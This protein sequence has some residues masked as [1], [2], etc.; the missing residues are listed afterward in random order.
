MFFH[1]RENSRRQLVTEKLWKEVLG[2]HHPPSTRKCLKFLKESSVVVTTLSRERLPCKECR[3]ILIFVSFLTFELKR[4]STKMVT[5]VVNRTS[6]HTVIHRSRRN[7][8]LNLNL[9]NL[10]PR[11]TRT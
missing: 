8:L 11:F 2:P 9:R 5:G 7:A 10:T 4:R 1:L 3:R 6:V